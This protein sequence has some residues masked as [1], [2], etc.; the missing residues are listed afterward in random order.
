MYV[1][2]LSLP[3][4][5]D[6]LRTHTWIPRPPSLLFISGREPSLTKLL[7]RFGGMSTQDVLRNM[8]MQGGS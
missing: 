1:V 7:V 5:Y 3:V 4:N 8:A 6:G 2:P